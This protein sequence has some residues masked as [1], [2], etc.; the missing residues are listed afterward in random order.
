MPTDTSKYLAKTTDKEYGNGL[1]ALQ[2]AAAAGERWRVLNC[3][4]VDLMGNGVGIVEARR[5]SLISRIQLE[6]SDTFY[7]CIFISDVK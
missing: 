3:D 2:V 4:G 7:F 6:V 1:K 5:K